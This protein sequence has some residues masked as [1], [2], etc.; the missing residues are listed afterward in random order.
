MTLTTKQ[1]V[2]PWSL[3]EEP[4]FPVTIV[5]SGE[6]YIVRGT[7]DVLAA[8]RAVHHWRRKE[9][10]WLSP[11]DACPPPRAR[12]GWFRWNPCNARSCF[13]GG[14]H[15]GHVGYAQGPGR[16]NFRGVELSW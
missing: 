8:K 11:E 13:D 14:G 16:G 12:V 4:A 10:P 2:V 3:P 9:D 1:D 6:S 15:S 5:D 7:D